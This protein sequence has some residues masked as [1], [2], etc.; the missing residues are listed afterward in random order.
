MALDI[1]DY[2]SK[3]SELC[4]SYGVRSLDVF[5]SAFR[6]DFDSNESDIDFLVVFIEPHP[7][8][9]FDCYFELKEALEQ[10]FQRSVDLVEKKAIK[11]PYFRQA[12]EQSKVQVYGTGS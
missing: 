3:L 5:G 11:N 10:L 9:A 1:N 7:L 8:G 6:N 12:V 4:D 2:V